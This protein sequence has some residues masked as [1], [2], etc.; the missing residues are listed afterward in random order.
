MVSCWL[1]MSA[2]NPP[3]IALLGTWLDGWYQSQLWRGAVAGTRLHGARLLTVVGY[4]RPESA[5]PSTRDG[6]YGLAARGEVQATL[7]SVGP[8]CFWEGAAA[9]VTLRSWLPVHPVVA[10]GQEFPGTD[11][12]LPDGGGIDEVARHLVEVHGKK[13]IAYLGGPST[14]GRPWTVGASVG[15]ADWKPQDDPE[16]REAMAQADLRLYRDKV[17]RKGS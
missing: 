10:L 2:M 12:V 6:V 9:A 3:T 11:S 16:M 1:P 4:A 14:N 8:L 17:Y 15:W 7:L 5:A 13:R